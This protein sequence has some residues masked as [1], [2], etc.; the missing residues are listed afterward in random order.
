MS[1]CVDRVKIGVYHGECDNPDQ[2]RDPNIE[3]FIECGLNNKYM[4][5]AKVFEKNNYRWSER[6][7]HAT[8]YNQNSTRGFSHGLERSNENYH[9]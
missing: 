6:F 1:L 2:G 8:M 3:R 4:W 9:C 5:E 7:H